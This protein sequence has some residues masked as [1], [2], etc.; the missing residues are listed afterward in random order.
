MKLMPDLVALLGTPKQF[1]VCQKWLAISTVENID[2][3][4]NYRITMR[5]AVLE[6][7]VPWRR[8]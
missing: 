1:V 3:R 5:I 8:H 2:N 7:I 6:V 4:E